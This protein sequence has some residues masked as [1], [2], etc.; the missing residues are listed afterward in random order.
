MNTETQEH[1]AAGIPDDLMYV[2]AARLVF[3]TPLLVMPDVAE[4]I[5][6]YL[7]L[8]ME[9]V[10]PEASRFIG[11]QV[12]DQSGA[13]KGYR[14]QGNVGIISITGEL[15][16]RGAWMGASSGLTSYEGILEQARGVGADGEVETVVLDINSPGGE[17]FGMSDASRGIRAAVGGKKIIA[18]I[19]SVGA[20]AAYGLATSADE[21]VVT[22]SGIA[23]S[24]GVVMVHFDQSERAAKFGVKATV[25][26]NSDG[27]DK[28]R[29][30]SFAPLSAEDAAFLQ[31]KA[32]RIMDG[33]VKLVMDHRP[34]LTNEAIRGQRARTFLGE[35]AVAAGLADRVGSFDGVMKQLASAAVSRPGTMNRRFSMETQDTTTTTTPSQTGISPQAHDAAVKAARDEGYKAGKEEG[36]K[37]GAEDAKTR[38]A[39]ILD[40]DNAKGREK[41]SRHLAFNTS[42]P[43]DDAV[44]TMAA[45]EP[46]ADKGPSLS[47]RMKNAPDTSLGAPPA[48]GQ[49]DEPKGFERGKAIAMKA[50]GKKPAA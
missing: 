42:M 38:I 37:A 29:G 8:R 33:F 21:I 46:V 18:V 22:E 28:A 35:D 23:G 6:D 11:R 12:V 30:H 19:N 41:L 43:A 25:I 34:G 9:G 48:G 15:V 13:W 2:R 49:G 7:R 5:G 32:D 20:S 50:L 40:S 26:T 27:V 4:T 16:N 39:A 14:R 17:A 3:N 10:R 31:A 1:L 24:I 44:A 45:S 47:D 36:F